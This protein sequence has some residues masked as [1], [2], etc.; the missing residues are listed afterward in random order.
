MKGRDAE[1][2]ALVALD[3]AALATVT[4]LVQLW[5]GSGV[6]SEDRPQRSIWPSEEADDVFARLQRELLKP[7]A[8]RGG[9]VGNLLLDG[10][11]MAP[12]AFDAVIERCCTVGLQ[13]VPVSGL[14]RDGRYQS[15]VAGALE[16]CRSGVALRLGREDFPPAGADLS[17]RIEEF[18]SMMRLAPGSVDVVLDLG[19]IARETWEANTIWA[20]SALL[21]LPHV[22]GWRNLAVAATGT[23]AYATGIQHMAIEPRPRVEW[24]LWKILHQERRALPRMPT[25]SDYGVVHPGRVEEGIDPKGLKRIPLLRYTTVEEE[26]MVRGADL[27]KEPDHLPELLRRLINQLRA[28]PDGFDPGFSA[29]DGWIGETDQR[30]DRPGN[31][32]TWKFVGQNRHLAFVSWQLAN[33]AEI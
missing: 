25:Y 10:D 18:L 33:L 4:P 26:L 32:T 13:P 28:S 12:E 31:R 30:V 2:R 29:G 8:D 24:W 21:V 6:G 5:P 22:G 16:R 1:Y 27:D 15:V 23:P 17:E 14:R 11:W 3:D 19:W 20:R 9:H 7:L